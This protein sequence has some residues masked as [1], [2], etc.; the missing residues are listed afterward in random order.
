MSPL[1]GEIPGSLVIERTDGGVADYSV[2]VEAAGR[3]L[4]ATGT[5]LKADWDVR[6]F[7]WDAEHDPRSKPDKWKELIAGSAPAGEKTASIDYYWGWSAPAEAVPA[8]RF[9]TSATA[10]ITLPAGKW[11]VSTISDDGVRVWIDGKK[12]IDN[13]K[14]HPPTEDSAVVELAEGQHQV[15]IEHFDI[16]GHAQLQF[17]IEPQG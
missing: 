2:A 4:T 15:R 16:D 11:T 12:V 1:S 13:W 7:K 14:W 3:K 5:L 8:D 17:M 9:G 6:W 10:T